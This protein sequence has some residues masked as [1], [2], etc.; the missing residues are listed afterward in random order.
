MSIVIKNDAEGITEYVNNEGNVYKK[1]TYTG[2]KVLIEKSEDGLPIIP[3]LPDDSPPPS[4][5]AVAICGE[6]G[7]RIYPVMGYV[8]NNPRCPCGFGGV[9]CNTI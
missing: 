3:P 1:M 5:G 9:Q 6:C 4:D 2:K 8:C 7:M